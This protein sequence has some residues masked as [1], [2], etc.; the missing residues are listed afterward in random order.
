MTKD[1]CA[2]IAKRFDSRTAFNAMARA[3]YD[4]ARVSGWLDEICAHI[5]VSY[6]SSANPKRSNQD[7][8][9]EAKRF[10]TRKDMRANA[11]SAY[12]LIYARR[13]KDVAFAHMPILVRGVKKRKTA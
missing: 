5:T 13:L 3:A 12:S 8:I 11:I 9:E 10:T 6:D 2:T 1:E 7:L 4:T